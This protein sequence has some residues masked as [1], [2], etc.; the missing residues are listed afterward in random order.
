MKSFGLAKKE[1]VR[2]RERGLTSNDEVDIVP[3]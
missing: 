3:V 2:E 1:L